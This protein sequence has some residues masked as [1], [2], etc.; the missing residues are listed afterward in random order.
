MSTDFNL[1]ALVADLRSASTEARPQQAV[2]SVLQAAM[3]NPDNVVAG[4]PNF[5]DN[6]VVLFEDDTISIWH[7]RFMPGQ[8]VPAHD[9]QMHA[10]IGVYKGAERNDF[11]DA[12]P[13]TGGMRKTVEVVLEPGKV[14][15]IGPDAIHAVGCAS[16]DPCQG[17]HV[18]LGKLTTVDRSLFD[19]E[20]GE[21]M[22]F[23]DENYE[24]LTKADDA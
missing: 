8:T 16:D 1:D 3:S 14:L 13:S 15:Q 9:H 17:I 21:A 4:M 24:R 11:Y 7:C 22:A 2:K 23:S 10:T 18:Y 6:D 12:D 5:E 20:T 19:T